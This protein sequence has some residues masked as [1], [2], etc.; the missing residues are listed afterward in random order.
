MTLLSGCTSRTL[1]STDYVK[2]DK[3]GTEE[4]GSTIDSQY[5]NIQ[6]NSDSIS[7]YNTQYILKKENVKYAKVRQDKYK[8]T[9]VKMEN[10]IVA[11]IAT[12]LTLVMD[13][14]S[15]CNFGDGC[16]TA[17]M[18]VD[19]DT[20]YPSER[21]TVQGQYF[22]EQ[23]QSKTKSYE[24]VANKEVGLYINDTFAQNITTN[25]EGVASY[26]IISLINSSEIRPQDLI[27]GQKVTVKAVADG[28]SATH[29]FANSS[30]PELYFQSA[31][32]RLKPQLVDR[33]ARYDNCNFIANSRRE[34]FE[35]Y[36]YQE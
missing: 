2:G 17:D 11:I 5:F 6:I 4:I 18:W 16:T 1:R 21:K 22:T 33:K 8:E 35:C 34:F 9:R 32:N 23:K 3:I 31:Y 14:F 36:Y 24:V 10:P 30:I 27:Y 25:Q 29:S 7:T 28:V 15:F 26:D 13:V 12:P 20:Y 19:I